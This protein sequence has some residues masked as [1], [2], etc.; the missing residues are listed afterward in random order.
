MVIHHVMVVTG[1]WMGL[2]GGF[3]AAG[4][5]NVACFCEVSAIFLNYRSMWSKSEQ[6][7]PIPTVNQLCFFFSY[8]FCRILLF[9]WCVTMLI[10]SA[11]WSFHLEDVSFIRKFCTTMSILMYIVVVFLNFF[12]FFLIL[13][14]VRKLLQEQGILKKNPN[15]KDDSRLD[16]ALDDEPPKQH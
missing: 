11:S 7:D 16:F 10:I 15:E 5:S 12:W 6:N 9:P 3:A 2:Y 13:K 4:V 8:F 1:V 14:G